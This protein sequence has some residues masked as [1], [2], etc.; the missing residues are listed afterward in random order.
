MVRRNVTRQDYDEL[1]R[2]ARAQAQVDSQYGKL[3]RKGDTYSLLGI[4]L[5]V[6]MFGYAVDW[7]LGSGF[8]RG[9]KNLLGGVGVVG[10]PVAFIC[11]IVK[12]VDLR[13][14]VSRLS[15][16]SVALMMDNHN[17][18]RRYN[19]LS[20]KQGERL[21]FFDRETKDDVDLIVSDG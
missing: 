8:I 20:Y 18:H 9:V 2:E 17:A 14:T 16:Q 21:I 10:F 13:I 3:L 5:G 12:I 1:F 7:W 6:V 19:L 4:S 11:V 15:R